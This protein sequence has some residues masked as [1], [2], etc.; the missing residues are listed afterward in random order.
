MGSRSGEGM[1]PPPP[2]LVEV[3]VWLYLVPCYRFEEVQRHLG[4]LVPTRKRTLV[5]MSY[6][7]SQRSIVYGCVL[8]N[9]PSHA[10]SIYDQQSSTTFVKARSFSGFIRIHMRHSFGGS[11]SMEC[12]SNRPTS[13]KMTLREALDRAVAFR[14]SK[15]HPCHHTFPNK[16]LR[17][18]DR[19]CATNLCFCGCFVM[20]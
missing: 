17:R 18:E 19:I 16:G 10:L 11:S 12:F 8:N 5:G 20:L 4:C 1:P 3:A 13:A 15:R 14:T 9:R 2:C 7:Q 6:R